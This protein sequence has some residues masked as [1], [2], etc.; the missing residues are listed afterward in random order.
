M[1][2]KV[3]LLTDEEFI[4]LA[5]ESHSMNEL[6]LKCGYSCYSG[7]NHRY[8]KDRMEKLNLTKDIFLPRD[9]TK[10]I[11]DELLFIEDSEYDRTT[12]RR[13]YQKGNY[14]EYKC[15]ICGQEPF[16]NGKELTL[17]LD[18]INGH[19]RDN[20]LENLRW[21]CPNCDRQLDTFAGKN[22]IHQEKDKNYCIDCGTE[23][24]Q[25]SIRCPKCAAI[26]VGKTHRITERP[27]REELKKRIRL[28]PF[29]T[30][31]SDYGV[32]DNAIRKWCK[33]EGLPST[34]K[35]IQ[36]ISDEE[37]EKI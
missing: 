17:T 26:F 19:N 23:I 20:R 4:Q 34:K 33:S 24:K 12:L 5:K 1:P 6:G 21:I 9:A 2:N 28:E 7:A 32:T 22:I 37:W 15:A 10:E 18:H 31:A 30:I 35:E 13:H 11:P 36:K 16:W 8:I 25:S 14:S 29:T 3:E 27:D